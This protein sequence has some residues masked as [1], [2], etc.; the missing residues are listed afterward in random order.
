MAA[1]TDVEGTDYFSL[2]FQ[3][4]ISEDVDLVIIEQGELVSCAVSWRDAND[5]AINDEVYVVQYC[6]MK[7]PL[8]PADQ[9]PTRLLRN[10]NSYELLVRTLLELPRKPAILNLK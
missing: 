10:L 5:A 2:C 7:L 4:H 8:E 9:G 3:E 6:S 1:R